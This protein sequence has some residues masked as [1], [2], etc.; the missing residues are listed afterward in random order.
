[1][2]VI[3]DRAAGID[4]GGK[5][6]FV[7]VPVEAVAAGEGH[8]RNFGAF[9][10][11]LDELV[12]WLVGCGIKTAAMES[13][14]VFWIPLY[15]K[16]E[17][18]GI[19]VVLVNARH[20]KNVPG[21]KTDMLDCQWLQKLHSCGLLR[22][23]FRPHDSICQ[24]RALVRHRS[25]L[26]SQAAEQVQL[27]QK[28][29]QQMN[30]LLHHVVSDLDGAT[31]LRILDAI[32]EGVREAEA[33][34]KLRDERLRKSTP[35]QMKKALEGDWRREQLFVLGQARAAH[36]FFQEQI[37]ECDQE[38]EVLLKQAV[39]S[40]GQ[41]KAA[42]CLG[43]P[44]AEGSKNS[45]KKRGKKGAGNAPEK[46]FTPLLQAILGVD[47]SALS[48]VSPWGTL[49]LLSEI[50][51]DMS[52]WRN[53]KAFSSWLGLAPNLRISGGKVLSSRTPKVANRAANMLRMMAVA[54]G[55]TET[56]MGC[57]YRRLRSRAGSPKAITGTA[58]KLACLIYRLI[59]NR[60]AYQPRSLTEYEARFRQAQTKR[61]ERKAKTL[62]Y[63]LVRVEE[64]KGDQG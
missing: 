37:K 30:I 55:K 18:A 61:L 44:G 47:L 54:A 53:E 64:H 6:H 7:C 29:L 52:R 27:M 22:G 59:K 36:R 51:H 28:A 35:E 14:G 25:G 43:E 40:V 41:P 39:A 21:R 4:I 13:T 49:V 57:F 1:M 50:G 11:D 24:V 63:K 34:V 56:P 31:G 42:A 9:T 23:A 48:G 12:K 38:I 58:R 32:L 20:V 17:Q 62:G 5:V 8:I 60:E 10:S 16:L 3:N 45:K 19:E 2:Q 26:I 33:L 15:Q 46:D